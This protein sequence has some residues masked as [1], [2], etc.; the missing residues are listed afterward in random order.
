MYN[1]G[2]GMERVILPGCN[3]QV[4]VGML[5]VCIHTRVDRIIKTEL[6]FADIIWT[7]R[8]RTHTHI[9]TTASRQYLYNMCAKYKFCRKKIKTENCSA[10]YYYL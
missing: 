9:H 3:K 7:A 6:K 2:G 10:V 4:I 5:Y 8:A 1:C